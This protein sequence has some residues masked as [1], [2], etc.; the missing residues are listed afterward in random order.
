MLHY[1]TSK[2][3]PYVQ[4]NKGSMDTCDWD[5]NRRWKPC[6][7]KLR[8]RSICK[9]SC[10][11][12]QFTVSLCSS[13]FNHK[14]CKMTPPPPICG[15]LECTFGKTR[16][17]ARLLPQE[18]HNP[19][20]QPTFQTSC[21]TSKLQLRGKR[22]IKIASHQPQATSKRLMRKTLEYRTQLNLWKR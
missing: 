10:T 17:D 8:T 7:G 19:T 1:T 3:C 12:S 11:P 21:S 13:Y 2:E 6:S 22:S 9:G 16:Q 18:N 15:T 20:T 4:V 14:I 5:S